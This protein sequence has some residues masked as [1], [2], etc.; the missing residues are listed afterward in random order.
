M[1]TPDGAPTLLG[2]MLPRMAPLPLPRAI[3][4]DEESSDVALARKLESMPSSASSGLLATPTAGVVRQLR[5]LRSVV[6]ALA[7]VTAACVAVIVAFVLAMANVW[8][9]PGVSTLAFA[10]NNSVAVL[11]HRVTMLEAA[12]QSSVNT[13]CG[14]AVTHTHT[15]VT[16]VTNVTSVTYQCD[17]V[18]AVNATAYRALNETR[19]LEERVAALE[20][21]EC[22]CNASASNTT[23]TTTVIHTPSGTVNASAAMNE[24][25]V[26][27]LIQ[28]SL[29]QSFTTNI[30]TAT[31]INTGYIQYDDWEG[32][33][34]LISPSV[35]LVR[36]NMYV[37][38]DEGAIA[39]RCC[40]ETNRIFT[41]IHDIDSNALWQPY[42][43]EVDAGLPSAVA[44]I[45]DGRV[46]LQMIAVKLSGMTR[47]K[48]ILLNAFKP[49]HNPAPVLEYA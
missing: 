19:I 48:A 17:D 34:A 15:H 27:E 40:A 16:N 4:N 11:E 42:L 9:L 21:Q 5:V 46:I 31:G 35:S 1:A 12:P 6:I 24:T 18:T 8:H 20:A 37:S 38:L 7:V 13:S 43:D 45:L 39:Y 30:T 3:L 26:L 36:K 10:A 22:S 33:N 14:C 44:Q 47:A 41:V 2:R 28:Q 29:S 49:Q 23:T 25:R 32:H